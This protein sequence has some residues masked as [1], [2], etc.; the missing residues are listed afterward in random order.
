MKAILKYGIVVAK[1][2]IYRYEIPID[3]I[4]DIGDGYIDTKT[5]GRM[6]FPSDEQID[7]CALLPQLDKGGH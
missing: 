6:K 1:G 3:D 2:C 5:F 7:G 4:V